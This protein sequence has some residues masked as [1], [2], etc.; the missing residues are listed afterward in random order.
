MSGHLQPVFTHRKGLPNPRWLPVAAIILAAWAAALSLWWRHLSLPDPGITPIS[1]DQSATIAPAERGPTL[2][3]TSAGATDSTLA[4][5]TR[6]PGTLAQA[7]DWLALARAFDERRALSDI[8]E[9]ASPRYAGRATGSPGG[10]LAAE[11]IAA[12]FAEYGLQPAGD[13]GTFMQEF[14]VPYGELTAMPSLAASQVGGVE[15]A[16]RFRADFGIVLGGYADGGSAEAAVIWVGDGNRADYDEL[17]AS[18]AIVLCRYDGK[19]EGALRQALE[20]GA[21][22]VL[23]ARLDHPNFAMRRLTREHPLLPQ[24]IPALYVGMDVVR[25]LLLGSG[26]TLDDLSIQHTPRLLSTRVRLAVPLRYEEGAAGRNVLGVLPGSDPNG[27]EQVVVVGAHYDHLGADPDGTVWGGANDNASGVAVLLE[28]AK[29]WQDH[30]FVP[31]RTVVFAAWDGEENG[32]WGSTYYVAHPRFPLT[33]TVGMLALDMVGAGAD[34]LFLDAGGMVA[35]QSLAAAAELALGASSQSLGRSDHA[36]FVA[37]GVPA[38]LFIRWDGLDPRI[39]YHVPSDDVNGI[40]PSKLRTAGELASLVVLDLCW[41]QEEIETLAALRS[42]A[43]LAQDSSALLLSL[44]PRDAGLLQSEGAWLERVVG[45]SLLDPA[46]TTEPAIVA[47]TTAT[48]TVTIRYHLPGD[49]LQQTT[50]FPVTWLRHSLDWYYAGPPWERTVGQHFV[51][52]HL[53]QAQEAARLA[54]QGDALWLRLSAETGLSIPVT[55]TVR[56]YNSSAMLRAFEAPPQP[57][58]GGAAW[59]TNGR[60]V[61]TNASVLTGTFVQAALVDAGWS[62]AAASWLVQGLGEVWT[63]ESTQQT[64]RLEERHM[65]VLLQPPGQADLWT[66]EN[67]P[68]RDAVP[69][70]KLDLWAA[71]A[72]AMTRHLI[73]TGGWSAIQTPSLRSL[74]NWQT[75]RLDAWRTAAAGIDRTLAQRSQAVLARDAAAFVATVDTADETLLQEERHWFDDLRDHPAQSYGITGR[76]VAL[77]GDQAVAELKLDYRLGTEG[78]SADSVTWRGRFVRRGDRWL[79]A[80]FQCAEARSEHFW[81]KY[82]ESLGTGFA[83]ELL[84]QAESAYDLVS[85]D[86]EFQPAQSVEIKYYASSELFR[87]SIYLSMPPAHGWTEPG[88]SIKLVDVSYRQAGRTIA[89]ELAHSALFARGVQHTAVHEGTGQYEAVAFDPQWRDQQITRWRQQVYDWV[90]G[91]RS[92]TF[93]GM[94]DWR[95]LY[96]DQPGLIYSMGWDTVSYFRERFGRAAFLKWLDLIGSGLSVEDALS[97]A[98][99]TSYL[100]F[101]SDWRESVLRGHIAPEDINI[102]QDLSGD[103]ALEHVRILAQPSWNGREAGTKGNEAAAAYVADR[104][105]E[106][107]LLPAGDGGTYLQTF[108]VTHTALLTTPLLSVLDT[109]GQPL[110]TPRYR[111]DFSEFIRGCAGGGSAEGELVYVPGAQPENLRLGGRVL[112]AKA[113]KDMLSQAQSACQSGASALLLATD[114]LTTEMR[115]KSDYL[116]SLSAQ[117]MPVFLLARGGLKE[118]LGLAG[119]GGRRLANAPPALLLPLRAR[120]DVQVAITPTATAANVLG[121]LPGS[122]PQLKEKVLIV[123]AHIDHVGTLPDGTVYPGANDDASGIAVLLEIARLWH[124]HGFR[125]RRTVVFAAW[126]AE[127]AGLLG[128]RYFV[129]HPSCPLECIEAVLQL[130]MVGQGRGYYIIASGDEVQEARMRAHLENAARQVEGRV[131][132]VPSESG[133]DHETFHRRGIPAVMLAW[134]RGENSHLPADSVD[135]IDSRK[136][137]STGRVAALALMTMAGER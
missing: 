2:T 111:E 61:L 94:T 9:L 80:D 54:S 81:L 92:P 84:A 40:E 41:E 121:I 6:R 57:S 73:E 116:P 70:A 51:V 22:A 59:A 132:L 99:G 1:F 110:K 25:D 37:A 129:D 23:F 62:P 106:Y 63:S 67:M 36:P 38:T 58:S 52:E 91:Q 77:E 107:G 100:Q 78:A 48:T 21:R 47:G 101:D 50:V 24:G 96:T 26:M 133:S 120:I 56:L 32:L 123:S 13:D 33:S 128:S 15:K 82:A 43:V 76:L 108:N 71:Q 16:Y 30:G 115:V 104:F 66:P 14:P 42:N 119:Y 85:T 64:L 125:P 93:V 118:L 87:S 134:E 35:D 74:R 114:V 45:H 90:R 112:L 12:R 19:T 131:T 124:E 4:A 103:A 95:A 27:R 126:N 53:Q 75:T 89:H 88:E 109:R 28:M 10:K 137:Q 102:A 105:A 49:S 79:Y 11:W 31:K 5:V 3:P 55:W 7:E 68:G 34:E 117:T 44:Y 127:E 60:I 136:L 46:V 17:D 130:D 29:Q 20:H 97:A 122:D 72:W 113:G 69:S 98:T 65:P 8:A 83:Q 18:G 86:L 39:V 135:S